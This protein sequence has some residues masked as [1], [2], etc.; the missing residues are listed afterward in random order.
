MA[1]GFSFFLFFC[2]Y[3]FPVVKEQVME[4]QFAHLYPVLTFEL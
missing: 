1:K 3:Y 2:L 4:I